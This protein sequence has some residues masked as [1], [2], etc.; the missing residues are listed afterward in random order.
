MFESEIGNLFTL[1]QLIAFLNSLN[2]FSRLI[3]IR[4]IWNYILTLNISNL[5]NTIEAQRVQFTS[6]ELDIIVETTKQRLQNNIKKIDVATFHEICVYK[7]TFQMLIPNGKD[8]FNRC[9][10]IDLFNIVSVQHQILDRKLLS[11]VY[12]Y[13]NS[14]IRK[15]IRTKIWLDDKENI[16]LIKHI[17]SKNDI[18]SFNEEFEYDGIKKQFSIVNTHYKIIKELSQAEVDIIQCHRKKFPS[19]W[20]DS[21]FLKVFQLNAWKYQNEQNYQYIKHQI[22]DVGLY[23]DND[24]TNLNL[25]KLILPLLDRDNILILLANVRNL[26]VFK[27]VVEY[28]GITNDEIINSYVVR[29]AIRYFDK[30]ILTHIAPFLNQI[31]ILQYIEDYDYYI[32]EVILDEDKKKIYIECREWILLKFPDVIG[33]LKRFYQKFTKFSHFVGILVP[34][35]V[36]HKILL[37]KHCKM[38]KNHLIQQYIQQSGDTQVSWQSSLSPLVISN[39]ISRLK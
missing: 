30:D 3:N 7:L 22:I 1:H 23:L 9:L 37:L 39:I 31:V 2:P 25:C 29:N 38:H 19:V 4:S 33:T 17:I 16:Q 12:I 18:V 13:S 26:E 11:I 21:Y 32:N 6:L 28:Y 36:K 24:I 14:D 15:D 27:Y 20:E 8:I 5:P 10:D 34:L 35:Y